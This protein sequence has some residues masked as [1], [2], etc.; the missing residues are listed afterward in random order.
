[1]GIIE[2][3]LK[4]FKNNGKLTPLDTVKAIE[5]ELVDYIKT[6]SKNKITLT[7]RV[8]DIVTWTERLN[9]G[10]YEL[11]DT[12]DNLFYLNDYIHQVQSSVEAG[13]ANMYL[14]GLSSVV[15]TLAHIISDVTTDCLLPNN[16]NLY[17]VF[18]R[19][20][21][22]VYRQDNPDINAKFHERLG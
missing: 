9:R 22:R 5:D 15:L 4:D 12:I 8:G 18:M 11:T 6:S 3:I 2:S 10:D 20:D 16:N 1:M 14:L 17:S 7:I 13:E 19:P 21:M